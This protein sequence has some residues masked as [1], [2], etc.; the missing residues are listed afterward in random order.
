MFYVPLVTLPFLLASWGLVLRLELCYSSCLYPSY[1]SSQM[2]PGG[3]ISIA[4]S[5]TLWPYLA[6]WTDTWHRGISS[7]SV[8]P[9]CGSLWLFQQWCYQWSSWLAWSSRNSLIGPITFP[10]EHSAKWR[11]SM[12]LSLSLSTHAYATLELRGAMYK[13]SHKSSLRPAR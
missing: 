12:L 5:L 13:V 2:L 7:S 6:S 10:I 9:T 4:S 1:S 3:H 8:P 11:W